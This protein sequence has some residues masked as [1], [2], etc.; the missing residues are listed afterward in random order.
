MTAPW[1]LKDLMYFSLSLLIKKFNFVAL[2][3]ET[4]IEWT[5][6]FMSLD[7]SCSKINDSD[8][9]FFDR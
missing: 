1:S 4:K 5:L 6:F 8:N 2:Y 7:K 9:T 3:R